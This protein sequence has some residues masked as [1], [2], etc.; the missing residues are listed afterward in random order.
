MT[1]PNPSY[2]YAIAWKLFGDLRKL[3]R[4]GVEELARSATTP[5]IGINGYHEYG[6]SSYPL[7]VAVWEAFL[8]E[9]CMSSKT[10][11]TFPGSML[12][13]IRDKAEW[14]RI[15]EKTLL[16]PK[17]LLG[18]TFDKSAPPYK[19]F[20]HLVKIRNH[21]VHF[22]SEVVPVKAVRQL[23]E[24]HITFGQPVVGNPWHLQLESTECVRWAIN[25]VSNMVG[26]LISLFPNGYLS[27]LS[28][29]FKGISEDEARS[30]LLAASAARNT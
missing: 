10:E 16:I 13:D 1:N 29:V 5:L 8:N 21:I 20:S 3:Y 12:W 22:R 19:D 25:V 15:E 6:L 18:K 30:I 14:W 26:F 24:R 17:L 28:M 9:N 4:L 23:S 7:A 2:S 27:E 11:S